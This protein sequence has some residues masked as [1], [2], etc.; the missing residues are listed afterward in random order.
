MFQGTC[1]YCGQ[2]FQALSP[3][4]KFCKPSHRVAYCV[5]SRKRNGP[6]ESK[7]TSLNK[8]AKIINSNPAPDSPEH[9]EAVRLR[10]VIM[11]P[12]PLTEKPK[13]PIVWEDHRIELDQE[14]P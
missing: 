5:K 2:P 13:A 8:L 10:E 12:S 11:A 6:S 3:T 7:F 1:H 4:K 9:K 14:Q